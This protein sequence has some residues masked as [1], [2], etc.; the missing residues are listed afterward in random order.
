MNICLPVCGLIVNS[1]LRDEAVPIGASLKA[2]YSS[3][4]QIYGLSGLGLSTTQRV[5]LEMITALE[6]VMAGLDPAIWKGRPPMKIDT[7]RG[8][9]HRVKPTTVRFRKN[10]CPW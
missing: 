3:A 7:A 10:G 5:R 8:L 2:R 1:A 6:I 9:D 4:A